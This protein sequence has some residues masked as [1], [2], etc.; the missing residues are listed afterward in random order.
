MSD[1]FGSPRTVAHQALLSVRFPEQEYWSQWPFPP[2]GDL[3]DSDIEPTSPALQPDS[4]LLWTRGSPSIPGR[5]E[6]PT[7]CDATKPQL[8]KLCILEPVP[9][10]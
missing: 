3:P 10:N 1:S 5:G 9:H 4:L 7:R 6:D 2:P 8:L